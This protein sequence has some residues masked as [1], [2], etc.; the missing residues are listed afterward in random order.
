MK[1]TLLRLV[2][3]LVFLT[4]LWTA[5]E[6]QVTLPYIEGF[7]G[8]V[9]SILN[10]GWS[11]HDVDGDGNTWQH[12]A[13]TSHGGFHRHVIASSSRGDLTP[14]NWL[15][16]PDV[17][18]VKSI[19][20]SA[21]TL[22]HYCQEHYSL[23]ISKNTNDLADFVEV[24]SETLEV[25]FHYDY[26]M[27]FM[28]DYREFNI[29]EGTKYI[30]WR[31]HDCTNQGELKIKSVLF[32][33]EK[34]K[35][36]LPYYENFEGLTMEELKEKGWAAYDYDSDGHNWD[37][38][39]TNDTWGN[40]MVSASNY[41]GISLKPDNRLRTPTLPLL[42]SVSYRIGSDHNNNYQE[43]YTLEATVYMSSP[44]E[45]VTWV[46]SVPIVS[47]TINLPG[48]SNNLN[49]ANLVYRQFN[50][51]PGTIKLTW[52][53]HDCSNQSH[54][55]L[56]NVSLSH[57][58]KNVLLHV[59]GETVSPIEC[60][61]QDGVVNVSGIQAGALLQAYALSGKLMYSSVASDSTAQF[62]LPKGIYVLRLGSNS[63]KLIV[64]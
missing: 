59:D 51:P 12:H 38:A 61:V 17:S 64:D 58:L 46:G 43:H 25:R 39:Y 53:H 44:T 30:A 27:G 3:V 5:S 8:G 47:E 42:K 23:L 26:V 56:D 1:K 45:Y 29:P 48:T 54:L 36:T 34:A 4:S 9:S 14:D 57:E 15:I 31:H 33:D 55:I 35:L 60:Y 41:N 63:S 40:A 16:S 37:L 50:L 2:F 24:F 21:A 6:A 28:F 49:G 52:I 62:S 7:W 19:R 13:Y 32:S 20:Y 10:K 18:G 11:I 22:D